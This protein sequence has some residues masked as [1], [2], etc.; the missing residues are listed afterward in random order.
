MTNLA[1]RDFKVGHARVTSPAPKVDDRDL[2][3]RDIV[4]AN[5]ADDT[6][7]ARAEQR[8]KRRRLRRFF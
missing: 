2:T 6:R 1:T 7:I 8:A 3:D 5:I 4:R